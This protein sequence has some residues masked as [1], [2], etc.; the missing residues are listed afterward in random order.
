MDAADWEIKGDSSMG[1]STDGKQEKWNEMV[2]AIRLVL[3]QDAN[4][5]SSDR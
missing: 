5:D 3:I 1:R 4:K 2:H